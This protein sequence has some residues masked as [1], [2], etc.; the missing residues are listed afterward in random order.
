[1]LSVF[2]M[3]GSTV[4]GAF[5]AEI[6][7]A[8]GTPGRL[9]SLRQMTS[10]VTGFITGP[11]SGYLGSIAFAF[12]AGACGLAM[13]LIVPATLFLMREQRQRVDSGEVLR[14]AGEKVSTVARARTMWIAAA[15]IAFV[16]SAPGLSTAIFYRQQD[17]LHMT[18]NSGPGLP[19]FLG[20]QG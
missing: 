19:G 8:T 9:S 16:F 2:M 20:G 5:M 10:L 15:V 11:A 17:L 3:I 6:A 1:L 14:G 7:Q 4:V 13:F 18:T 12:T